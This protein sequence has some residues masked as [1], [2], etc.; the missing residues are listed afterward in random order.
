VRWLH[1]LGRTV[2][3][4]NHVTPGGLVKA[5]YGHNLAVQLLGRVQALKLDVVALF[6]GGAIYLLW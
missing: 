2:R 4:L 1:A 5:V 3:Q 6:E